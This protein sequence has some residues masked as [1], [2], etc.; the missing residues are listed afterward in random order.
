MADRSKLRT[1]LD[2]SNVE[3]AASN[4]SLCM[5]VC[6]LSVSLSYAGIGPVMDRS[7]AQGVLQK[8]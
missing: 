4:Y 2:C 6:P 7:L 5:D 3:I 1:V 8:V